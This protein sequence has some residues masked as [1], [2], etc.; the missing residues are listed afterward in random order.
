MKQT[1]FFCFLLLLAATLHTRAQVIFFEDF[2]QGIPATFTLIN[3]DN[4][5]PA[6]QVAFV[7]NAWVAREWHAQWQDTAAVSTSWYTVPAQADDWMITPPIQLTAKST[8]SWKAFAVDPDFRDGYEVRI[9]TGGN[10]VSDFN[11]VLFSTG[12]EQTTIT[13]RFADLQAYTGQT[14]YIAFRNNSFNKNLLFIDDIKV[15]LKPPFDAGILSSEMPARYTIIPR[16]QRTTFLP[17]AV[18]INDGANALNDV[19]AFCAIRKNNMLQKLDS[20]SVALLGSGLVSTFN[21][22]TYTPNDTGLFQL[23]YFTKI[24]QQDGN[25]ANDTAK[26]FLLVNDTVYARDN[27]F[28]TSSV[29]IGAANGE[30]GHW[31]NI[32]HPAKAT[33]AT[34]FLNKPSV[35]ATLKFKLYVFG[36]SPQGL[37]DSTFSYTTTLSDSLNG[38]LL[39]LSFISKVKLQIGKYLLAVVEQGGKKLNVGTCDG[40]QTSRVNWFRFSGNPFGRWASG[41]EYDSLIATQAYTNVLAMRLNIEN[42]CNLQPDFGVTVLPT[43]TNTGSITTNYTSENPAPYIYQWSNNQ[44]GK[45]ISNLLP[46]TYSL[47]VTDNFGCKFSRTDTIKVV[48]ITVSMSVKDVGCKGGSNG[49]ATANSFG[50]NGNYTYVWSTVPIQTAKTATGLRQGVYT[51]TVT[52]GSCVTTSVAPVLEPSTLMQV[53]VVAKVNPS[54][55]LAL[56]GIITVNATNGQPPYQ[57]VWNDSVVQPQLSGV[58]AGRYC[59]TVTDGRDCTIEKCDTIGF[60]VSI[61][62]IKPVIAKVFPIPATDYLFFEIDNVS[63]FHAMLWDNAG[64][65]VLAKEIANR[66]MLFVGNLADGIY[67]LELQ[68]EFSVMR[69]KIVISH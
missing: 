5:T 64:K 26:Y 29:A 36:N 67:L 65:K 50:G 22:S 43:C 18:V 14:V 46:G 33:S 21:F 6:P 42:A 13:T 25:L 8:L 17:S 57:Y 37:V 30:F 7:N 66:D 2:Q 1:L 19:K 45:G 54:S 16:S 32:V 44:S 27:G 10:N 9:S 68:N 11:T 63:T 40:L 60:G 61:A 56:D 58:G 41:D 15:E 3:G 4:K 49:A 34:V 53:D 62:S 69:K 28:I 47:T 52:D 24:Q 55:A 35:G 51:V 59:V 20:N 38:K 39:T 23:D 31:F 12:A 48:P